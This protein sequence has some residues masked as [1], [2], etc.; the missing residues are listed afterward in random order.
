MNNLNTKMDKLVQRTFK[1]R[2]EEEKADKKIE[3]VTTEFEEVLKEIMEKNKISIVGKYIKYDN[4]F[5][6]V[7]KI[8]KIDICEGICENSLY[9]RLD[10]IATCG[11][12][13]I[14]FESLEECNLIA[15]L[16]AELSSEV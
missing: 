7:D 5:I 15:D 12:L 3:E 11:C 4:S 16:I 10:V 14:V 6:R 9:V 8:E 2:K 13:P 1:A